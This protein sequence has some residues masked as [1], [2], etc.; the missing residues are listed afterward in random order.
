MFRT[1][2]TFALAMFLRFSCALCFPSVQGGVNIYMHLVLGIVGTTLFS[3]YDLPV[4]EIWISI[5]GPAAFVQLHL[6]HLVLLLLL[7]LLLLSFCYLETLK[8]LSLF[9]LVTVYIPCSKSKTVFWVFYIWQQNL[10]NQ[11]MLASLTNLDINVCMSCVVLTKQA[12]IS[13]LNM[14]PWTVSFASSY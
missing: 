1:E 4:S 13:T 2:P 12:E 5:C 3:S 11:D 6:T 9:V 10:I 14:S 7:L 8:L